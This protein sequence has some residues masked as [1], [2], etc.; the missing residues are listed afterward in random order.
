M[1]SFGGVSVTRIIRYAIVL[2]CLVPSLSAQ[3]QQ[4]PLPELPP[5]IPKE[6]VIRIVLTDMTPSGHDAIWRSGD[7]A[8]H[9]FFQFN[10]RGRGP[11]IYTTYRLDANGLIVS[12][13]SKGVD[14][15]KSAVEEHFSL[16]EG[17]GE[18]NFGACSA[19]PG[20]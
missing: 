12:E 20:E 11:K 18:C 6:A 7:G 17:R 3:Q 5:D 1:E 10:D 9:E 19:N 2:F 14:Y 16:V 15:M 8:I 4:S 13:E